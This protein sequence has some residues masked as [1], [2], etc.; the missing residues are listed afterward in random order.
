MNKLARFSAIT[1][2]VAIVS[3]L[4]AT[5]VL[6]TRVHAMPVPTQVVAVASDC[7]KPKLLGVFVP[8]YQYLKLGT[9]DTGSCAIK[10]FDLLPNGNQSSDIP[11]VLLAVVDD[12]LRFAG[13]VA[14]IFVVYGGVQYATSQGNPDSASKAQST[15]LN[16][17]IGLAIAVVAVTF[18][19][20]LGRALS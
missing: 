12:L 2:V 10:H 11:L 17:L 9:D 15:I 13:L 8:W 20:F 14:V 19:T 5:V 3:L 1:A 4:A 6:P 16:A 18:V 7:N